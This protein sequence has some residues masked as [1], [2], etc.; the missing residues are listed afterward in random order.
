[1]QLYQKIVISLWVVTLLAACSSEPELDKKTRILNTLKTMEAAIEAKGLDEF[2]DFVSDD[3]K[4][5]GRGWNK[6]DAERLLR[7]RLMR[8]KNVHVHQVLKRIDWVDEGEDQVEVE[9]VA[10]MAG[11]DFSLTDMPSFR[12]DMV[13]FI[14][15]FKLIEGEYLVTQTEW[16][17]AGPADFVL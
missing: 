17:R 7:I 12:G 10:A 4:S 2:F 8:N 1:M 3:F 16:N 14:V 11:T 15:T 6:K 9:V 13:K 5:T